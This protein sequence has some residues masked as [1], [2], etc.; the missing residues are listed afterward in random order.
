MIKKLLVVSGLLLSGCSSLDQNPT[1][2]TGAYVFGHEVRSFHPCGSSKAY[3]AVLP[4]AEAK[5]LNNLSLKKAQRTGKPYQ[6]VFVDL[7]GHLRPSE[8]EQGF[9]ADYDAVL[10]VATVH[11]AQNAIP[12]G[13]VV[14]TG[15]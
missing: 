9:A 12:A 2:M 7:T 4:E 5:R 3:W 1:R 10:M 15:N 8:N 14:S 11:A 13:C 6:P